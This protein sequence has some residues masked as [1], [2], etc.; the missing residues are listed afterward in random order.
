MT[1]NFFEDG[2]D[3][4]CSGELRSLSLDCERFLTMKKETDIRIPLCYLEKNENDSVLVFAFASGGL[5]INE[6]GSLLSL[7]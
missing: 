6:S 7:I 5:R 1:M 3:E 2:P 4:P